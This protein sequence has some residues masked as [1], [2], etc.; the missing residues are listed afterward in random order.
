MSVIPFNIFLLFMQCVKKLTKKIY[1][2]ANLF[3][4]LFSKI[5]KNSSS[6]PT[7]STECEHINMHKVAKYIALLMSTTSNSSI[8]D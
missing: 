8:P 2:M 1:P 5:V 4:C 3:N 7:K 6:Y